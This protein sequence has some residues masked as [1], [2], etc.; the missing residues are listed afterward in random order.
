M[1]PE[2]IVPL[3]SQM[4]AEASES[5]MELSVRSTAMNIH[6]IALKLSVGIHRFKTVRRHE[7]GRLACIY[8]ESR[9]RYRKS[10]AGCRHYAKGMHYF[11][12]LVAVTYDC[13]RR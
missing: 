1:E 5:G 9:G 12:T 13:R 8:A 7:H 2:V 3:M 10:S 4:T 6:I 11:S